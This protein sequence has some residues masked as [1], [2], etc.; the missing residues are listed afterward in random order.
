MAPLHA[1]NIERRGTEPVGDALDLRRRH[2]QEHRARID[3]AAD[4]PGTGDAVDLR[5]RSGDPDRAPVPVELRHARS[6]NER[7]ARLLPAHEAVF[8]RIG[9]NAAVP[10]PS[11]DPFAELFAL[12]ADDDGRTSGE[13]AG[14]VRD[15]AMGTARR[16]GNQSGVRLEVVVGADVDK[17]GTV[18]RAYEPREL[19]NGDRVDRRHDA[20][21][22]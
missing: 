21:L 19:F 3:E 6:R 11:R 15:I 17:D 8:Q 1:F 14:P 9:G 5:P 20:P 13:F 16:A 4:Q 22:L 10:Q 7:Q 12:L 2:E 18:R